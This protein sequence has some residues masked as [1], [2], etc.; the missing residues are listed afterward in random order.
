M[1]MFHEKAN[2]WESALGVAIRAAHAM[3]AKSSTPI[4]VYIFEADDGMMHVHEHAP[5][6]GFVYL[7]VQGNGRV[8][9]IPGLDSMLAPNAAA[10]L[11]YFRDNFER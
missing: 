6:L 8:I 10:V 4:E 7:L 11:D 1:L 9:Y 5:P 2:G 3:Q